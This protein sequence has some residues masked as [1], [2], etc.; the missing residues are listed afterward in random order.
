MLVQVPESFQLAHSNRFALNLRSTFVWSI[1]CTHAIPINFLTST[2]ID[3]IRDPYS[4]QISTGLGVCVHI[5]S[6]GMFYIF[7]RMSWIP[8]SFWLPLW[9]TF[10]CSMANNNVTSSWTGTTRFIL[11][12]ISQGHS[13]TL[14]SITRLFSQCTNLRLARWTRNLYGWEIW[15][16]KLT[17]VHVN[18]PAHIF[19]NH[20][21]KKSKVVV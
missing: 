9:T 18:Y 5:F 14:T 6:W 3:S 20:N 19:S 17:S 16:K 4:W 7:T 12:L 8:L 13:F 1:R 2:L 10:V 21:I 15:K 11:A